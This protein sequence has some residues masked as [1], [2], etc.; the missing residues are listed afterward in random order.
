[1][2][3]MESNELGEN[4]PNVQKPEESES[5]EERD[6][7]DVVGKDEEQGLKELTILAM[8]VFEMLCGR[9][10]LSTPASLKY[11]QTNGSDIT[12]KTIRNLQNF[13]VRKRCKSTRTWRVSKGC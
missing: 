3:T 6:V 1:M 7:M 4:L 13:S 9:P 5:Q 11:G 10:C 8:E 2:P 12:L